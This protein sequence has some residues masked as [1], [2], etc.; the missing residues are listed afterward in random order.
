MTHFPVII[1]R[2]RSFNARDSKDHWDLAKPF[3]LTRTTGNAVPTSTHRLFERG[4]A[5]SIGVTKTKSD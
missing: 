4:E 2:L 5:V 3:R 1:T